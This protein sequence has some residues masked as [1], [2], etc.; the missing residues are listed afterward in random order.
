MKIIAGPCQLESSEHAI[1]I[2]SA[3][4]ELCDK[5]DFEFY[6]KSSYDKANRTSIHGKRGPGIFQ[7]IQWLSEVRDE[8]GCKV[9]TDVHEVWHIKEVLP[10][11]DVLQIPAF[12]CRQTDLLVRSVELASL[13]DKIVNI[14]KG[15]FLA[16][17]D[18]KGI[19]SKTGTD[20][21][22]ITERG[23]SFGY[24]T[25][26]VDFTGIQYMTKEFDVPIIFDATHCVQKP[27]GKG[28]SSDGNREYVPGLIRAAVAQGGID[29][30]FMECHQ[31]PDN[32]PSDGP[33]MLRLDDVEKVFED[34]KKYSYDN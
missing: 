13:T 4:K 27:G 19:L 10:T 17:W 9:L 5:Y 32:A 8:V 3:L 34:I 21:V 28:N 24:N 31:D 22:W 2:A 26:T 18:V 15:Q 23:T 25:L 7:G 20:N 30:V 1:E 16:P 33:N 6:F 11:V 14:K 29:G 12:L